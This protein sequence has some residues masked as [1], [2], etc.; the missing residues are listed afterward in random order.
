MRC[1]G[2]YNWVSDGVLQRMPR[3]KLKSSDLREYPRAVVCERAPLTTAGRVFNPK[4]GQNNSGR[5]FPSCF[6]HVH[7]W[8]HAIRVLVTR[9]KRVLGVGKMNQLK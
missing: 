4:P 8:S 2:S 7:L 1:D 3:S 9:M 5:L 6:L